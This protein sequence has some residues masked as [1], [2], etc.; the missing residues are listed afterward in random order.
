MKM[1]DSICWMIPVIACV[2]LMTVMV[3]STHALDYP[4]LVDEVSEMDVPPATL[5]IDTSTE[6]LLL[7]VQKK[8][9]VPFEIAADLVAPGI[10]AI[11]KKKDVMLD[12]RV[13]LTKFLSIAGLDG[14]A[15]TWGRSLMTKRHATY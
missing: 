15:Q 3:P 8:Y 6:Q 2:L 9:T 11:P 10:A 12:G 1:F 4:P 14:S 5:V 7:L 13:R